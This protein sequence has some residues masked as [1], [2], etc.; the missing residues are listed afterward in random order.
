MSY[1]ITYS[2]LNFTF[3]QCC[4]NDCFSYTNFVSCCH[5]RKKVVRRVKKLNPLVNT[6]A[7]LHLNPFAAVLKREAILS[8]QRRKLQ[9]TKMLAEKRGVSSFS[10]RF[11]LRDM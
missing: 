4:L 8:A 11:I 6:K 9:R 3:E 2:K 5:Y 7:M 10:K 1:V